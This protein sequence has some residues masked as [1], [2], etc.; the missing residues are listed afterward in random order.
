MFISRKLMVTPH[1]RLNPRMRLGDPL[2]HLN[3]RR[4]YRASSNTHG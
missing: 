4:G 2:W 3:P 1:R